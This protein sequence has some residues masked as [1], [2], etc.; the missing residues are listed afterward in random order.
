MMFS[1][2]TYYAQRAT[3]NMLEPLN[4]YIAKDGFNMQDEYY[5]D[6]TYGDTIYGL[7]AKKNIYF[8]MMNKNHLDEAGLSVPKDWTWDEF[9]DYSKKLTKGEGASKRYGSY[10]HTFS[11]YY[12]LAL[13]NQPDDYYLVK[14]DG[15]TLN[16]DNSLVRR[17]LDIRK[18]AEMVDKSATPYSETMSQKLNYRPQYFGEKTSMIV[19]GDFMIPEAGGSDKVP[20]NF[21]T[22]F[23]PYPKVNE[24]DP[25]STITAGDIMGVSS[26]SK[27]KQ[28]AYDFVR[29]YTT[30]GIQYQGKYM[31]A[32]KKADL[33]KVIDT[34]IASSK[35]PDMIDRES[36]MYTM[37]NSIPQQY[38][39]PAPINEELENAYKKE[40]EKFLLGET[41][42]DTTINS[43][44]QKGQEI[45]KNSQ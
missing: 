15:K 7:P 10:F 25:I 38:N 1:N 12:H 9:L 45:I 29:W 27:H 17:S 44:V 20:A 34:L 28:E 6:T 43:A 31:S 14:S 16:I 41:D 35:T 26:K 8:V 13:S 4:D 18:Q 33:N 24:A 19:T 21:Q 42:V 37:T 11:Q 3:A 23:A 30:E 40:V 39:I 32:W 22:V 5:M 36:L 2:A